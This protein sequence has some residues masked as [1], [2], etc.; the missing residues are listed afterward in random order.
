MIMDELLEFADATALSTAGTGLAAVG[1]VIDLGATP[2][3][4]GNGRHM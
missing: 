2:Q 1:D 3:D 4:L